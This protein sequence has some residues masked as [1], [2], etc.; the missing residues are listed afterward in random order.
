VNFGAAAG[1]QKPSDVL[2]MHV[3]DWLKSAG[4]ELRLEA[5]TFN[6][7]PLAL[8]LRWDRGMDKPAPLGGD[9]YTFMIGF[10]FDNWELIEEPDYAKA[11]AGRFGGRILQ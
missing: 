8:S 4:L 2:D 9:R 1:W 11:P 5:I 10:D 6:S 3:S 7:L